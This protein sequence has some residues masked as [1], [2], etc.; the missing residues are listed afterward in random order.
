MTA[1]EPTPDLSSAARPSPER[2]FPTLSAAQIKRIAAH[3]RLREVAA[4]DVLVEVGD[5]QVPFFVVV[6][7]GIEV[8]APSGN[9]LE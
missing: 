8:V 6:T 4:G 2:L 5:R 7:G 3:G 9:G 1:S